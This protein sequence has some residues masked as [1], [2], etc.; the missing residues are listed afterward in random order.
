MV[1]RNY[2]KLHQTYQVSHVHFVSNSH[3]QV[4]CSHAFIAY[5]WLHRSSSGSA[6]MPRFTNQNAGHISAFK[7]KTTMQ[8]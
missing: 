2:Y 1:N 6:D 5:S 8:H 3:T 7:T 4:Y